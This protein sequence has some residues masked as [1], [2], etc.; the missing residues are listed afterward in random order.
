M[1]ILFIVATVYIF[2]I[3]ES[4]LSAL[5][6]RWLTPNL[7]LLVIIFF[8]LLRGIRYS[9]LA[10]LLAGILKDSYSAGPMG[11]S[12]C[13]FMTCAYLTTLLKSYIYQPGSL[14]SRV[15]LVFIMSLINIG[16]LYL[17]HLISTNVDFVDMF[18]NVLIPEITATCIVTGYVFKKLRQCVSSFSV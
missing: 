13:S 15:L 5:F 9:I 16:L 10:A 1:R 14:P 6:G 7:L 4:V 17:L 3:L 12:V 18:Q 11:I 8:N 2:F